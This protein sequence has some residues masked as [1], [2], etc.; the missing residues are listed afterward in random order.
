M[1]LSAARS[2]V[3]VL[4]EHGPRRFVQEGR[5]Y[6]RESAFR[7]RDRL[8]GAVAEGD[9]VLDREWDL[10]VVL[11]GCRADLFDEAVADRDGPWSPPVERSWS[12]ASHSRGWLARNFGADRDLSG[13]GYVT[14]NPFSEGLDA[15]RF[16]FVDEAWRD[17]WDREAGTVRPRPVTDRTVAAWRERSPDRLV[18]HY[19]Q[20][21]APF[22]D[23]DYGGAD[24]HGPETWGQANFG[25]VWAALRR[26][27]RSREAVWRDYRRNLDLVLDEVDLLLSAVDADVV[28]T[29]DHGNC[30]GEHGLYGHPAGIAVPELREVPWARAEAR[31]DGGYEPSVGEREGDEVDRGERLAALGYA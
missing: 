8:S 20:P 17:R 12:A 7:A 21:H 15:D 24:G 18:A 13:V 30:A 19:M 25:N 16:A 2:G 9:R 23:A 22:L 5:R 27:D 14:A 31:D 4:R 10:L 6:A 11:D 29:A 28:A 3:R 1:V 26:G